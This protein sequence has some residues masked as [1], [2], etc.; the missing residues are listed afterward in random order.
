MQPHVTFPPLARSVLAGFGLS[1]TLG[2]AGCDLPA[3]DNS[4]QIEAK[5]TADGKAI[6]S[7]C[8]HA[9]RS[10]EECYQNNPKASKAAIFEG[11]R[12]M[13][14]YM[15]EKNIEGMPGPAGG[16]K[17]ESASAP[18]PGSGSKDI[19]KKH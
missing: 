6:G 13:D 18:E 11:W 8:R 5:K 2:L 10:I 1:L 16:A 4:A 3:L 7:G 12:D 14:G 19:V 9:L 17:A 15:R